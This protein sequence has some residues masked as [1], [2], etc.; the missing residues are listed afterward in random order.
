MLGRDGSAGG[1]P[2][3][4]LDRALSAV[5]GEEPDKVPIVLQV[6]SLVLKRLVGVTEYEYYQNSQLQI[7]AKVAFQKRF[8]ELLNAGM[9]MLPEYAEFVGPIPTAFGASL[10]WM[11]DAP[12]YV[13][14]CPIE[15]PKDVDRLIE[16][17]LPDPRE[18]GVSVEILRRLEYF[19]K[20]F[21]PELKETYWYV[22][23]YVQAGAYL[24]GAAL[25]MGYDNFLLWLRLHPLSLH[26]WLNFATD[27]YLE[28]CKAIE[29][30]VGE[31]RMLWVPDHSPSMMGEEQFR[32]FLLPY[33]NKVFDRYP[34][35]LKIWHNEGSVGHML[36]AIDEINADVW[37]FGPFDI[38]RDCKEKTHF[39]L[40]GNIHPPW[41]ASN[42]PSE[43][44]RACRSLI[45][46]TAVGGRFWLSTGGGMAPDTPFENIES[47]IKAVDDYGTYPIRGDG[48]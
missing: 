35:A 11:E 9:G 3:D 44:E 34:K 40:Q 16:R 27:W 37:H 4:V 12:P 15:D 5:K 25:T 13:S 22:D 2:L 41:L 39:C 21:P 38:P 17:G 42:T 48:N 6:Y 32:E 1:L 14:N 20:N 7:E 10:E 26:K 24:E 18:E 28:Y 8:P 45:D 23:G 33:L 31:C 36:D 43:I 30:V 19:T 47:I 46:E 29:E